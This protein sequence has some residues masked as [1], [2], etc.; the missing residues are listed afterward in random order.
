GGRPSTVTATSEADAPSSDASRR[1]KA[2]AAATGA[3][4]IKRWRGSPA[5]HAAAKYGTG[6]GTATTNVPEAVAAPRSPP[7]AG[8]GG[9][10][11]PRR[12]GRR[13]AGG[14]GRVGGSGWG[15]GGAPGDRGVEAFDRTRLQEVERLALRPA[16][17]RVD[18]DD[19]AG[20]LGFGEPPGQR[21]PQ[22][23]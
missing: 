17:L 10:P 18:E 16:D 22:L 4:P 19:R 3:L 2:A 20:E 23:P 6:S 9:A 15:E 7:N 1:R 11:G 8:R 13:G 12:G 14:G 5:R 21:G